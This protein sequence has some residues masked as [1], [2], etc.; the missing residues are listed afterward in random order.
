M[1]CLRCHHRKFDYVSLQ[2][3]GNCL[4]CA[5]CHRYVVCPFVSPIEI[6]TLLLCLVKIDIKNNIDAKDALNNNWI[7]PAK[8]HRYAQMWQLYKNEAHIKFGKDFFI[9]KQFLINNKQQLQQ[10]L[11]V[12]AI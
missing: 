8:N 1:I 5:K 7:F 12:G 6:V 2:Q 9:K 11:F 3:H 4:I 10:D